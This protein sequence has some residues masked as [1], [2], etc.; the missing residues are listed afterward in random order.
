MHNRKKDDM[1]FGILSFGDL[2]QDGSGQRQHV[3]DQLREQLERIQLAEDVGLGFYG[4]GEHHLPEYAVSHPGS[5]LAAAAAVTDRITLSSAVTVLSTE[6]PVR[7]YQEFATIDQLTSGRAEII[8]GRGSF[9]ESFPLFGA[10]LGDYDALYAEKLGLLLQIDRQNPVSWTGQHRA[11]LEDAFIWPRPF[12]DHL[13]V[14]L[15]TGGNAESSVRAGS[16]GLPIVYAIIGGEPERFAPLVNLYREVGAEAGHGDLEV[17]MS[18]IGLISDTSQ[19]AKDTYFPYWRST[20][21]AGA[22]SRGWRIPGRGEYDEFTRGARSILA[23]SPSEIVD[24]L[25]P[26]VELTR[27]DRYG[28]QMDWSGVPHADVMRGIELLG[29]QVAPHFADK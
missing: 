23:G 4:I 10:S 19:Q 1:Q 22:K 20:M 24:R 16:L 28:L 6:D 12:G 21:E 5:V 18:G 8:A 25:G 15:G 9:T 11:P 26:V 14:S 27:P 13:K 29:T 7:L 3:R 17:T 2:R